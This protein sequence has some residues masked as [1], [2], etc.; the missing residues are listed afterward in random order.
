MSF[1]HPN[2]SGTTVCISMETRLHRKCRQ[3]DL[4]YV[5]HCACTFYL[6]QYTLKRQEAMDE[7]EV[8]REQFNC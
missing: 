6:E 8:G 5:M 7:G 3:S 1:T 2:I 4:P